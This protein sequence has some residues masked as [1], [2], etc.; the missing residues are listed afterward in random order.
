M[1]YRMDYTARAR[2]DLK[3]LDRKNAQRII[4]V[5]N[6]LTDDPYSQIK[7]LKG[8][9][10]SQPIFTFRIGLFYRAIL[11]IHDDVLVIHVL[12]IEDRKKAYRD[13]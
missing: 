12:E 7:K 5:L 1:K 13:F 10:P 3:K 6:S 4:R 11:S 2:R 9:N 8:T